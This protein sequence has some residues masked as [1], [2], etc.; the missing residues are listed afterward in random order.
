MSEA[1]NGTSRRSTVRAVT[2]SASAAHVSPLT[3]AMVHCTARVSTRNRAESLRAM[4]HAVRIPHARAK[5]WGTVIPAEAPSPPKL[6]MSRS[7]TRAAMAASWNGTDRIQRSP[8]VSVSRPVAL[9]ISSLRRSVVDPPSESPCRASPSTL[10]NKAIT[11]PTTVP[12]YP[13]TPAS[14]GTHQ[15]RGVIVDS[16]PAG[17]FPEL[18][19]APESPGAPGAVCSCRAP[20]PGCACPG[21]VMAD[22]SAVSSGPG[23][24]ASPAGS[25]ADEGIGFSPE[26]HD[27]CPRSHLGNS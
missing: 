5:Y 20:G 7:G 14:T 16:A 21:G 26:S 1:K 2:I 19:G 17:R 15:C 3:A 24:R 10:S 23:P 13:P 27:E 8:E 22:I 6:R 9:L 12:T 4:S 18:R 11:V 25:C